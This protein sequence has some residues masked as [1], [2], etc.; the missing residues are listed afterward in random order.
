MLLLH[1][2]FC[3]ESLTKLKNCIRKSCTLTQA[4]AIFLLKDDD[5]SIKSNKNTETK[6]YQIHL[7]ISMS[8]THAHLV[9]A[10]CTNKALAFLWPALNS[11]QKRL[12]RYQNYQ[13]QPIEPW[14]RGLVPLCVIKCNNN[15]KLAHSL[16]HSPLDGS[17]EN[18]C[19]HTEANRAL[20]GHGVHPLPQKPQVLHLLPH[21]PA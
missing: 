12:C 16:T 8:L 17:P 1:T 14:K 2:L 11:F 20:A 18:A 15:K 9:N 3:E 7:S 4:P 5:E 10:D 19:Q 13:Q 6:T 21:K